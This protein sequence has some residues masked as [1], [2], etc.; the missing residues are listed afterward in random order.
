MGCSLELW[1]NVNAS[2]LKFLCQGILTEQQKLSVVVGMKMAFIG[3]YIWIF[4]LKLVEQF[5]KD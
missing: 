2:F 5:R 4:S 1:A 3:S